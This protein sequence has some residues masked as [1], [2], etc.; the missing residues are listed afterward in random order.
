[1]HGT[2]TAAAAGQGAPSLRDL[3]NR[4][5]EAHAGVVASLSSAAVHALVAGAYL[6]EAKELSGHGRF[7][8][9]LHACDVN[10][11]TARQYMQLAKLGGIKTV[12][13]TDLIETA[14][15]FVAA[16]LAGLSVKGAIKCLKSRP[17]RRTTSTF[18]PAAHSERSKQTK[19]VDIVA[20]WI[21][22]PLEERTRAINSIGFE[23]LLAALPQDW[24]P[25]ILDRLADRQ[26]PAPTEIVPVGLIPD[27]LSIPPCLQRVV[28]VKP[29]EVVDS[30]PEA[31]SEPSPTKLV[32]TG[33]KAKVEG[34][35]CFVIIKPGR[36]R[37]GSRLFSYR[38]GFRPDG[39]PTGTCILPG[40][41]KTPQLAQVAVEDAFARGLHL[42]AK[43][44]GLSA[45]F[46][47]RTCLPHD[48]VDGI[49]TNPPYGY[50]GRLACQ[51]IAHALER[52]PIVAMLLQID[53]DSSK[54]RTRLFRDCQ[55]FAGK[56]VL[57]D[58]IVWFEREGA[59]GPSENHAWYI[60]NR[61]HRGLP[62]I[63]YAQRTP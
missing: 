55:A 7:G 11:R 4:I 62:T 30:P 50:G 13:G 10:D 9:F 58:R 17:T 33:Q 19:H 23:P 52:V 49:C 34:G 15:A 3:A 29:E 36:W 37:G 12:P 46:L 1:M 32:W 60:W 40:D 53:F 51:F 21:N 59:P 18:Q 45:S 54:T 26:Q 8:E 35:R 25:L 5:R 56:I 44:T 43:R 28:A 38:V 57:L 2:I 39:N 48:R 63:S 14:K 27:D 16:N 47:L 20:A 31:L 42:K 24:I 61:Q 6:T 41:L 22:A